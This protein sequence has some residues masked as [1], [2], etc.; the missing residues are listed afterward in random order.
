[1]KTD[2]SEPKIIEISSSR[3]SLL[4]VNSQLIANLQKRV[5]ASRF[6]VAEGDSTKLGYIRALIQALQVQNAILKDIELDAV[7]QELE[8]LKELVKGQAS[9]PRQQ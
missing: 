4:R 8:E 2:A 3:E 9:L 5:N 6:R 1:M 7:K